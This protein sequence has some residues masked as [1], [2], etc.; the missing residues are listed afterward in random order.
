[1][2]FTTQTDGRQLGHYRNA[3]IS[4]VTNI[5]VEVKTLEVDKSELLDVALTPPMNDPDVAEGAVRL[6]G[7]QLEVKRPPQWARDVKY[8][9]A[10]RPRR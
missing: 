9:E 4:V 10:L 1:M 3:Y 5:H 7:W 8:S 6:T 2:N